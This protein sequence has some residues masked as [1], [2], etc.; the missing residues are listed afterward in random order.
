MIRHALGL[1]LDS[2]RPVR[3][4]IHEA[5][6]MGARGVVIEAIGELSPL[7]LSETGRRELRHLLRTTELS[8]VAL[9]LPTRRSFD[10]TDQLDDRI[11][12]ADMAF[13]L[14]Y[15]LGTNL[16]LVRAG[17][18]PPDEDRERCEAFRSAISSLGKR[19]DHRGVRLAL[20]TGSEPGVRLKTFLDSLDMVSLAASID[21]AS[22]LRAGLDPVAVCRE[23]SNWV[24][25]AYA[26]DAT[27]SAGG[28]ALNPRGWGF[29]AGALDWEEYL[30]ALEEV[31]YRGLLTVWPDVT[32]DPRVRFSELVLMFKRF[33]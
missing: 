30:G 29:P 1:R 12:R 2:T 10:T 8:L 21:P 16:V 3:D 6:N 22:L 19:A 17:P 20:E 13:A 32:E 15:E 11:R 9:S 23:L 25:H 33:G 24:A 28:V 18:L 26:G 4:Q 5:A 14:A 7:R 31:G 27:G